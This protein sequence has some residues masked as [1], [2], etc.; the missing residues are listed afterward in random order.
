MPSYRYGSVIPFF[1]LHLAAAAV[2]VWQHWTLTAFAWLIGSYYFR[3]FFVTAGYHRYFSHRSYRLG[4]ISQFLMAWMAQASAQKGVLW[5]AAHH[6]T[7]H[8]KSDQ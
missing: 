2:L 7:H 3:M 6:R 5:W 8:R 1:A 4:R